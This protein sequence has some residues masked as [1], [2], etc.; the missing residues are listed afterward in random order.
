MTEA[1]V[2]S[3]SLKVLGIYCV[4]R[5]LDYLPLAG[6]GLLWDARVLMYS[7]SLVLDWIIPLGILLLTSFVLIRHSDNITR[8]FFPPSDSTIIVFQGAE[9]QLYTLA[10]V[11]MGS[12][13]LIQEIPI[14]LS[15]LT[16]MLSAESSPISPD[17]SVRGKRIILL[18]LIFK[19]PVG[20]FLVFGSRRIAKFLCNLGRGSTD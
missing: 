5:A 14:L 18:Q 1:K 11:F 12:I 19:M 20:L 16:T 17:L 15:S 4:I 8:R 6:F 3:L 10:F 9:V 7:P 2:L 13:L